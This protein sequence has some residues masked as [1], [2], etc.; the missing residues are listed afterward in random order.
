[1]VDVVGIHVKNRGRQCPPQDCCGSQVVVQ[2]K[3]KVI[4][5]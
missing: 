3:L 4:K 2:M 1:M 5:E